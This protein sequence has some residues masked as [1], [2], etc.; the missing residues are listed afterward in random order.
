MV[1]VGGGRSPH[2]E[3][4]SSVTALGGEPLASRRTE[5]EGDLYLLLGAPRGKVS[6]NKIAWMLC[7]EVWTLFSNAKR[8]L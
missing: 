5:K 7:Q 3:L 6:L 8:A 1:C 4:Y 2:R